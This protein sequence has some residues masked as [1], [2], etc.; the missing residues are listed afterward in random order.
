MFTKI[1][2]TIIT[3]LG[4]LGG[5]ALCRYLFG[6]FDARGVLQIVPFVT[7]WFRIA[8]TIAV[9][10]VFAVL[11]WLLSKPVT[12]W[13]IKA[14]AWIDD[15]QS[16]KSVSDLVVFVL[17]LIVGLVIAFLFGGLT[18]KIPFTSVAL[19]VN[20]L[21]YLLCCYVCV[22]V[23]WKR[24]GDF[25][26][27]FLRHRKK[28]LIP[29]K[30]LDLSVVTDGRIYEICKTGFVEGCVIVPDFV[31]S[32]LKRIAESDDELKN[33]R[34]RRGLEIISDI[35]EKLGMP[36][37]IKDTKLGDI[38]DYETKIL[39]FARDSGG[40][41]I[42]A[43]RPISKAAQVHGIR[44]ININDLT[45]AVKAALLPGDERSVRIVREGR[46]RAQGLAYL[47]DG[48]M[49]V[50]EDGKYYVGETVNVTVT[51]VLQT[52]AG[53]MIFAALTDDKN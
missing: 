44:V 22:R 6:L 9:I 5:F 36:I 21:I 31:V 38:D 35:Q 12:K 49:I 39:R 20:V 47:D 41:L 14:G 26:F 15:W 53:R 13:I 42:T 17:A 18:N 3:F 34:G 33:A 46:E 43:D 40:T 7:G 37:E 1:S 2:R 10:A 24:R 50:V 16:D 23:V 4:G 11:A 25:T 8:A 51:S 27:P 19:T 45:N 28:Q 48:T 52:S 32:E 30:I 29:P